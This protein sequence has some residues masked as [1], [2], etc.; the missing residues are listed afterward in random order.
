MVSDNMNFKISWILLAT[1][2]AFSSCMT[3]EGCRRAIEGYGSDHAHLILNKKPK[4]SYEDY[5]LVG[6]DLT[7]DRDTTIRLKGRWYE[8]LGKIWDVQDT[9]VKNKDELIITVKKPDGTVRY[10]EWTCEEIYLDGKSVSTGLPKAR[11]D[12]IPVF[13]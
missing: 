8:T 13:D 1:L 3:E 12:T 11:P 7:T 5:I 6:K 4:K 10:S 2:F 9:V